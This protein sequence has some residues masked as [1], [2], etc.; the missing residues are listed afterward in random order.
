MKFA[1]F[2]KKSIMKNV[3]ISPIKKIGDGLFW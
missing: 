2:V 3:S 1:F